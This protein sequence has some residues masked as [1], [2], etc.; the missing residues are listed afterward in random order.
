VSHGAIKGF[1]SRA[2]RGGRIMGRRGSAALPG[3]GVRAVILLFITAVL[4]H[5]TYA[6]KL[7]VIF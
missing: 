3:L 4:A 7:T 1:L 6:E 5:F 2:V